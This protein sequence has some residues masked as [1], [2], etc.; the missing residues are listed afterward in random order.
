MDIVT[1]RES[2]MPIHVR[3]QLIK[4]SK[5][6]LSTKL[7]VI[8]RYVQNLNFHICAVSRFSNKANLGKTSTAITER[9]KYQSILSG[10]TKY[11][12]S[13]SVPNIAEGTSVAEL[14]LP[15]AD[16]WEIYIGNKANPLG[17]KIYTLGA[18]YGDNYGLVS[19]K[20]L[21]LDL[22]KLVC[23][24]FKPTTYVYD[25]F[26]K[27]YSVETSDRLS[28]TGSIHNR[29][30]RPFWKYYA[31]SILDFPIKPTSTNFNLDLSPDDENKSRSF[32]VFHA[33]GESLNV[34]IVSDIRHISTHVSNETHHNLV[35][36]STIN[37]PLVEKTGIISIIFHSYSSS[38]NDSRAVN[39]IL[40]GHSGDQEYLLTTDNCYW[41]PGNEPFSSFPKLELNANMRWEIESV[42][43]EKVAVYPGSRVLN[44][45]LPPMNDDPNNTLIEHVHFPS[46][47]AF[48]GFNIYLV[49]QKEYIGDIE[50][51]FSILFYKG[52]HKGVYEEHP[53][54]ELM[55]IDLPS[56]T[57]L[58]SGN[59]KFDYTVDDLPGGY[60]WKVIVKLETV[61]DID[62]VIPAY[63]TDEVVFNML[64]QETTGYFL[65]GHVVSC[66]DFPAISSGSLPS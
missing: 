10:N 18:K 49:V 17:Y 50:P 57:T 40:R 12:G 60:Y 16:S 11:L 54:K 20:V 4:A 28:V 15:I 9:S 32:E 35:S 46:P 5:L 62:Y 51:K 58:H 55:D 27:N 7:I 33:V 19:N 38:N 26:T 59:L 36:D 65:I 48:I 41:L 29:V 25:I 2:N 22:T 30:P 44:H 21:K 61:S 1:A 42:F 52:Q 6:K 31:N 23:T 56:Y 47:P 43:E 14:Y 3:E 8:G 39:L 45:I 66:G 37:A 53:F 63:M 24:K 34:H 13:I 64:L